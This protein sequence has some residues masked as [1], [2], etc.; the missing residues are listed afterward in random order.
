MKYPENNYCLLTYNDYLPTEDKLNCHVKKKNFKMGIY[1]NL[2][3]M[4]FNITSKIFIILKKQR[5]CGQYYKKKKTPMSNTNLRVKIMNKIIIGI[6]FL[7][8][9]KH[10]IRSEK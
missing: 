5:N 6:Q 1:R 8:H 7:S 9:V 2:I 3:K 4:Y 10:V